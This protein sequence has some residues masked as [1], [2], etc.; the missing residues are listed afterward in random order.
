MAFVFGVRSA[1]WCIVGELLG[2]LKFIT[3]VVGHEFIVIGL[4]LCRFV[5]SR[6]GHEHGLNRVHFCF[7]GFESLV[8]RFDCHM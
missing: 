2:A 6:K 5:V 3:I 4:G 7:Y 1:F 8:G